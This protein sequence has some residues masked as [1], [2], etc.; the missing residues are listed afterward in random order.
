MTRRFGL[1]LSLAAVMASAATVHAG[2]SPRVDWS[3][4]APG[5][6]RLVEPVV[7][8]SQVTR[9]VGNIVYPS[10]REVWEYLL[11]HPDFAADL[12]RVLREG[13]Y[14][15]R[16][17]G[18]HWDTEDGRGVSGTVRPL[19]IANGRRIY[20]LEGQYDSKWLPTLRGRAVLILDSDY[21]LAAGGT[22]LTDVSVKGY[23]RIDNAF[24]GALIAIARDF[25]AN[26]FDKR[27]R[28]FFRHVARVTRRAWEDPKGL[29]ELMAA[30]PDVDQARLAEF[31][32]LLLG[33]GAPA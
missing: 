25:S 7:A 14:R 15:V 33:S 19:H 31:R 10:R 29:I 2:V 16:R 28:R 8:T 24:V 1:I 12:A 18:D 5:D 13:K 6:Q 32:R 21:R 3:H 20:Y 17:V 11:D 30:R 9:E 26:T 27:V 23:L 22:P 4:L